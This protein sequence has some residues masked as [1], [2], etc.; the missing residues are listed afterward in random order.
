[1]GFV[2]DMI[3]NRGSAGAGTTDGMVS[4][5]IKQRKEEVKPKKFDNS[6]MGWLD[7]TQR[8]NYAIANA[9]KER[10]KRE[11]DMK[12]G[13]RIKEGLK[14]AVFPA[15]RIFQDK[16]AIWQGLT[17]E[18]KTYFRDVL[19][20][21]GFKGSGGRLSQALPFMY[22]KTGKGLPL[23]REGILD[24]STKGTLGLAM[25]I[26]LDPLT[27]LS[28]GTTAVPKIGAKIGAKTGT[29][30]L[31]LKFA[32]HPLL[33][34]RRALV[35]AQKVGQAAMKVPAISKLVKTFNTTTGIPLLDK[36]VKKYSMKRVAGRDEAIEAGLKVAQKIKI[37]SKSSG[38]SI[39]DIMTEVVNLIEIGK[40]PKGIIDE[41]LKKGITPDVASVASDLHKTFGGLLE[42]EIKAGVPI[43]PLG[44]GKSKRIAKLQKQIAK[45]VGSKKKR[46]IR[47]LNKEKAIVEAK[48]QSL[49]KGLPM[50]LRKLTGEKLT[51]EKISNT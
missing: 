3:S 24:P 18:K 29:K 7:R 23:K 20:E 16:K 6:L 15:R 41:A 25:D 10:L 12:F 8:I 35:G 22:S 32:G 27:Y 40:N 47:T 13:K 5:I 2:S 50:N 33:K 48:V 11:R 17:G 51:G 9:T 31:A 37:A 4:S 30:A 1:M 19:T 36:L 46:L 28:L 21:A 45:S 44:L 39:D 34:S 26:G 43:T 38:K 14:T 42:A 49:R